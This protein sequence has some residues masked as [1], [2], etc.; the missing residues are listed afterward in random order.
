MRS[1]AELLPALR[2]GDHDETLARLY[3][4]DKTQASL[5]RARDRAVGVAEGFQAAFPSN[6]GPAA[7]FS[8]PGRTEIGGNHT[9]HQHGRVL[10]GSVDLDLLAC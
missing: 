1:C 7:L 10:C 6:H 9:D 2:A 3:A 5:D 4:L 8:G